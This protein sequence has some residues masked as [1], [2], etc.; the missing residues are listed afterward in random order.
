MID[1]TIKYIFTIVNNQLVNVN[2]LDYRYA[3]PGLYKF[4]WR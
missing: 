1:K 2:G 3:N 4:Q